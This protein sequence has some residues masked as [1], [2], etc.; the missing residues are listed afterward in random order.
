MPGD[1]RDLL[2][3]SPRAFYILLAL[4]EGDAHGYAIAKAVEGATGGTV[5]LTPGT[6]YPSIGQM[7][8]DG[9]IAEI[10]VRDE[11]PRRRSYRLTGWGRRI[12]QAEA[13]RLAELVRMARN[14]KLLPAGSRV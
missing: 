9:W 6:L 4:A 14:C 7:L 11:D 1:P 8:A 13:E 3:L 5:R 10:T 2:P 12:A